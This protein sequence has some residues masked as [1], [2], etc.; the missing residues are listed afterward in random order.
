[1]VEQLKQAEVYLSYLEKH[2]NVILDYDSNL[3]DVKQLIKKM[4]QAFLLSFDSI[5]PT[6]SYFLNRKISS[7]DTFSVT[8]FL[9]LMIIKITSIIISLEQN[10]KIL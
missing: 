8:Y 4:K 1:M 7:S 6:I 10:N 9:F 3:S 2:P 5:I